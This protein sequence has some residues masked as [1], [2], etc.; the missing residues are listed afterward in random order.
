MSKDIN[1]KKLRN[2]VGLTLAHLAELSG[3]KVTDIVRLEQ[4]EKIP[5]CMRE[6]VLALLL[7]AREEGMAL[8]VRIWRERALRAENKVEILLGMVKGGINALKIPHD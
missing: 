6:C 1:F 2:D 8:D 3:Y 7:Q 4:G 5:P